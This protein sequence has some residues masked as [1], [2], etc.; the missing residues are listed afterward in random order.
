MDS[1]E[2]QQELSVETKLM[3]NK[4]PKLLERQ[5]K[6]RNHLVKT[7]PKSDAR[8]RQRKGRRRPI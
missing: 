5:K 1:V 3:L 6:V 8:L 4:F 2:K 7:N